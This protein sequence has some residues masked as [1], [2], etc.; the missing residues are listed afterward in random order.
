MTQDVELTAIA[1]AYEALSQLP[2]KQ[3]AR[4]VKYLADRLSENERGRQAAAV[5]LGLHLEP[6][7]F[8]EGKL[9]GDESGYDAREEVVDNSIAKDMDP[10]EVCG[11]AVVS[12]Q[13]AVCFSISDEDGYV[14]GHETEWFATRAEAEAFIACHQT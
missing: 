7:W 3:W 10:I 9:S 14:T 5:D 8:C 12:Q 13:F 6:I 2:S 4:A 1:A 11:Y